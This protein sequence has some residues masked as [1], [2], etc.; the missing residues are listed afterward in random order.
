MDTGIIAQ[1]GS[2]EEIYER[3]RSRFVAGFMVRTNLVEATIETATAGDGGTGTVDTGNGPLQVVMP[4]G[5]EAGRTI[6]GCMRPENIYVGDEGYGTE[7]ARLPGKMKQVS[8]LGDA[9]DCVVSTE[10]GEFNVY[11]HP[12]KR[13]REGDTLDLFIPVEFCC[14]VWD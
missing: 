12:S 3:P 4:A 2:P 8:Y 5:M 14:L 11:L 6:A 9:F 10:L 7:G 1:Q 13:I